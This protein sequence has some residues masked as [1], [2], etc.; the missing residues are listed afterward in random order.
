MDSNYMTFRKKQSYG[1]NRKMSR[2]QE[3]GV[4]RDEV[5]RAQKIFRAMKLFWSLTKLWTLW[6]YNGLCRFING[7]KGTTLVEG[8]GNR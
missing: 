1:G 4:G 7:N 2:C 6:N 8:V 5:G 3:L